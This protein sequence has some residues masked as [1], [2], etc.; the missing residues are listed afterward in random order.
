M[1]AEAVMKRK[2]VCSMVCALTVLFAGCGQQEAAVSEPEEVVQEEEVK[3]EEAVKEENTEI[4]EESVPETEG[5]ILVAY[6][7]ATGN[8]EEIA[9]QAAEL[10]GADLYEIEAE[11]PYTEADLA[12]YTGGRC[13]QEQDDP[14]VRPAISGGV[15]NM[16]QYDTVL[17][18]HP[19]WH[20]Q[21]PRIISTFLESYDFSGKTLVTFCT[22]ASS[23]LGSSAENLHPLVSDTVTWLESRRFA[24]GTPEEETG[25]WLRKIGLLK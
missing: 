8:T 24:A 25:Q 10:L 7:S 20:G 23:P 6:F 1:T 18:G 5:K 13:D 22:S 15:E 17:I 12:Y 19:I 3:Q 14:S 2:A 9:L 16:D 11:Q 21:A 4:P